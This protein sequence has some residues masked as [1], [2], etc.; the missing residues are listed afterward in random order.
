[1]AND[2]A[3]FLTTILESG[4]ATDQPIGQVTTY[5][6]VTESS[7]ATDHIEN[8]TEVISSL[9]ETGDVTDSANG[10]LYANATIMETGSLTTQTIAS[11][12]TTVVETGSVSDSVYAVIDGNASGSAAG[13]STVTASSLTIGRLL[14][15]YAV[16]APGVAAQEPQLL[17]AGTLALIPLDL[18]V[19]QMMKLVLAQASFTEDYGMHAWISRYPAGSSLLTALDV[20]PLMRMAPRPVVLYVPGQ[21]PPD[22][23][24]LAP[25]EPGAYYLNVL[26]L[27]NSLS[28]FSFAQTNLA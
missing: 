25:V 26:N 4:T 7:G 2:A 27:T 1:V 18:S 10:L 13:S 3:S 20:F 9:G 6:N 24:Y 23:T 11:I 22:A 5:D 28:R 8:I 16:F 14:Y 17:P 12:K 19:V 21:T 15:P